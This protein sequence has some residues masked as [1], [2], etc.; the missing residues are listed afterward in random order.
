MTKEKTEFK[1]LDLANKFRPTNFSE[2][3][4]QEHVCKLLEE[5]VKEKRVP[6]CI[7]MY[8]SSGVG[9]TSASRILASML[10]PSP[11]GT[12]EK[13]SAMEGGKDNIRNLQ[14][15]VYNKPFIGEYKTYIFDEAHEITKAAFA[16]LLKVTEEPP[17]HVKFIF[18]TTEFDKIPLNIKSRSQ[19]HSF[20][21]IPAKLI[22]ERVLQII[23]AENFELTDNL[24]NTVVQA[25]NGSL[26][27]SIIALESVITACMAGQTELD[28]AN[29][30]GILGASRLNEF[31]S[32]YLFRNFKKLHEVSGMFLPEKTDI[33][34][35]IYDLQQ[36]TMDARLCLAMPDMLNLVKSD[37]ESLLINVDQKLCNC[38]PDEKQK[39]KKSAGANLDILYDLSL[40]FESEVKRTSNKEACLTRFIVKLAQSWK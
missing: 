35:A 6:N 25:G 12:I 7:I 5:Q 26:R 21:R 20:N 28:I 2:V 16:S 22:K 24:L 36:Y 13:D 3:F 14:L 27:N 1:S 11:H 8:G 34:R 37:V 30:L 29:N 31:V 39:C 19:S 9:K 15:D 40:D 4:G 23:K 38:V 10:N 32:A 17:S 18:V 33:L